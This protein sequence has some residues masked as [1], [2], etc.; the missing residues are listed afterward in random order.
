MAKKTAPIFAIFSLYESTLG[1][2]DRSGPHFHNV[3]RSNECGLIPPAFFALAFENE[4]EYHYL[5]VRFNSSDDQAT[6]DINL[7]SS[8]ESTVYSKRLSEVWFVCLHSPGGSTV[9]VC[10]YLLGGRHCG[11][12][13]AIR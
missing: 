3:G 2:D 1:A 10:Y 13:Q 5:Y 4:L 11:T 7:V 6:A 12:E 8:R 9:M